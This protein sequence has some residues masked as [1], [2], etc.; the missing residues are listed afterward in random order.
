MPKV[1]VKKPKTKSKKF[2]VILDTSL[3]EGGSAQTC[4]CGALHTDLSKAKSDLEKHTR[5]N[6]ADYG[7]YAIA[8]VI[9]VPNQKKITFKEV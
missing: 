4:N 5:E 9:L 8:Q 7:T 2:Y 6:Y 1:K 3:K